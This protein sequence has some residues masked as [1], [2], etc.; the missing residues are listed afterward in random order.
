MDE[1]TATVER[2]WGWSG[3]RPKRVIE[4]NAFG[5]LLVLDELGRY[6]RIRPEDLSCA[7]IADSAADFASLRADPDFM[8]D[9]DMSRLKDVALSARG[10][11]SGN[12]AYCLKIASVLGGEYAASN[13]GDISLP[14]LISASGNLALQIRDLPDGAAINLQITE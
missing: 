8:R 2:S 13:I 7:V 5:N 3:L 14:E 4:R 11:I 1:L 10:P 12:R 6:W 9:W